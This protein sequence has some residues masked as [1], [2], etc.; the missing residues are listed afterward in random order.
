MIKALA[1]IAAVLLGAGL[2]LAG[3]GLQSTILPLRG[4]AEGFGAVALGFLGSAFYLGFVGGCIFGPFVILRSGHIRAFAAMVAIGS[5]AAL[6][7]PLFVSPGSWALFRLLFGFCTACLYVIVESWLNDKATNTTRGQVMS[8]YVLVSFGTIMLGQLAVTLFPIEY[9]GQFAL[10][11]ILLSLAA[12]P[13]ALTNSGQPAPIAV[14]RFR[15]LRLY[16]ATPAAVVGAT[17]SGLILGAIWGFGPVFA[18]SRGFTASEAAVFMSMCFVGGAVGQYPLGRIS[19]FYDRRIVMVGAMLSSVIAGIVLW[20]STA[21]DWPTIAGLGF[22]FGAFAFPGYSLAAAH[23]FD[24]TEQED[25]VETSAT[26]LLLYGVGS[27]AGPL[28]ASLFMS[29]LGS[30][31]LFLYC[32]IVQ[33][34]LALFIGMRI[35]VRAALATDEKTDFDIYSTAVVGGAITPEAV[36]ETHPMMETPEAP[37]SLESEFDNLVETAGFPATDTETDYDDMIMAPTGES[38]EPLDASEDEVNRSWAMNEDERDR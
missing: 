8:A 37:P 20:Q 36:D 35:R 34:A 29:R 6:A 4:E 16:Q 21:P 32:A 30:G 17:G 3:Y 24:V 19:D 14:V 1:P 18:T 15:P 10:A 26:V 23:A 33:L 22:V 12:V 13:I 11:S 27:V 5:A 2:M 9:F 25:M 7:F 28:V 38:S 31:G